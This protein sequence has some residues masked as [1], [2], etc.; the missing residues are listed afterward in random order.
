MRVL[1]I[2]DLMMDEYVYGEAAGISPEAPVMIVKVKNREIRSGGAGNVK[3][4]LE[5]LG[6]EVDF[7]CN[8]QLLCRKQR[9]VVQGQQVLRID[10][11]HYV[12]H[13][14]RSRA[15]IEERVEMADIVMVSDYGKGVVSEQ[16]MM[17]V[18]DAVVK[19]GKKLLI[20]PYHDRHYYCSKGVTL[21]KPNLVEIDSIKLEY[22]RRHLPVKVKMMKYMEAAAA[23]NCLVTMGAKGMLFMDRKKYW[24]NPLRVEAERNEVVDITGAGDTVFAV[25]GVIWAQKNFSKRTS[26][27]YANRAAGIAVSRFGCATVTKREVF[28]GRLWRNTLT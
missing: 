13:F 28:G 14:N 19:Y 23:E 15:E 3:A 27:E 9:I 11:D 26:I 5:A 4:N 12:E 21:I 8:E 20:D 7:L 6:A 1:L 16:L 10:G 25:L 24:D 22:P 2:G 17:K 18:G